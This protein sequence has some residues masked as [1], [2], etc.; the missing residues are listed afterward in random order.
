MGIVSAPPKSAAQIKAALRQLRT[1]G[2]VQIGTVGPA[3]SL[4]SGFILSQG[5]D[6][7][8]EVLDIVHALNPSGKYFDVPAAMTPAPQNTA[9]GKNGLASADGGPYWTGANDG[10]RGIPPASFQDLITMSGGALHLKARQADQTA[11]WPLMPFGQHELAAAING[12][13]A[14]SA[15]PPCII[16]FRARVSSPNT[17]AASAWHP[18]VWGRAMNPVSSWTGLEFDF[19]GTIDNLTFDA[20]EYSWVNGATAVSGSGWPLTAASSAGDV[21]GGMTFEATG[22]PQGA[23]NAVCPTGGSTNIVVLEGY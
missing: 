12:A 2:G 10:N 11:E 4:Y 7:D 1:V 20:N 21:G 8:G 13:G 14:F 23:I 17:A 16:E 6:F 15:T 18:S 5:D 3:G 19:E 9:R 22:V